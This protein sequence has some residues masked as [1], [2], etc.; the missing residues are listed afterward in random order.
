MWK[1]TGWLAKTVAAGL[2][3]S[4]L[5]IWTTGYIVNSYVETLLKQF[6]IPLDQKPFA[7]SSVWGGLWGADPLLKSDQDTAERNG[8]D[9]KGTS[10]GGA[11]KETEGITE[12]REDA[13]KKEEA[14][15]EKDKRE[16]T[17]TRKNEGPGV[18]ENE[19][20][21][22]DKNEG[23]GVDKNEG[24]SAEKNEQNEVGENEGSEMDEKETPL[25]VDAYGDETSGALTDIGGGRGP[26]GNSGA[27]SKAHGGDSG[28]LS[29]M[30]GGADLNT[31]GSSEAG[32]AL[33]DGVAITTDEL[34]ET[35]NGMSQE[36][37]EQLFNVMM[38]KLPQEAWQRISGLMEGGL[39]NEELTEV[40]QLI[41]QHLDRDEYDRMM[42]IMK[43]Y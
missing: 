2:I 37:K 12:Q 9:T 3:I 10:D 7:L 27:G 39:T 16:E 19:R 31:G 17:G 8:S 30:Q 36:D 14:A 4:F 43:K 40:Q 24:S 5:S 11:A 20:L 38:K 33:R 1:M 41:A 21:G 22:V 28:I 18:G 32:E 29:E 35:K 13:N 6:N 26:K 25:V 34:N 15:S 42:E 23:L